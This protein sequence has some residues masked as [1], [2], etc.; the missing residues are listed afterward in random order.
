MSEI[1]RFLSE[2]MGSIFFDQCSKKILKLNPNLGIK[3][4]E[5]YVDS[6]LVETGSNKCYRQKTM[7]I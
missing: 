4:A 7:Q 3:N 5:F 1:Y 6:E 2:H